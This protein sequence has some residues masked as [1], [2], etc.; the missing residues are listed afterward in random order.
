M[1][2]D[3]TMM[4]RIITVGLLIWI[5]VFSTVFTTVPVRSNP[6][7]FKITVLHTNDFH[8]ADMELL[9]KRA[10][11]IEQCRVESPDPV[12]LLD[13]GDVFARGPYAKRF[14]GE[15]EFEVM[16]QLQYDALTLGN[17]EF[18]ATNNISAQQMLFKRIRQARFPVLGA[19]VINPKTNNY[20]PGVSPYV[21]KEFSGVKIAIIGVTASRAQKYP[22]LAGLKV[23]DPIEVCGRMVRKLSSENLPEKPNIIIALTHIGIDEDLVLAEKV[24]GISAI[25]GGDSHTYMMNPEWINGCPIVHAGANGQY[26]G[27][28]DL[29]F[30]KEDTGWRLKNAEWGLINLYNDEI[31]PG[32]DILRIIDRYL[33]KPLKKAA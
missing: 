32:P 16:N 8:G 22:Q 24:P 15:L 31:K 18:K 28:L 11:V 1:N 10:A 23:L 26:L 27:K 13:A 21:I 3:D 6:A 5:I 9:A 30:I 14:F 25:I 7:I 12:L 20:L 33:V 2:R 17:N 4:K 19:N 29:T